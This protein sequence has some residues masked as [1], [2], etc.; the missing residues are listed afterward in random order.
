MLKNTIYLLLLIVSP[1]SGFAQDWVPVI[2][3]FGYNA[4]D[5]ELAFSCYVKNIDDDNDAEPTAYKIII[6]NISDN[7]EIFSADVPLDEIKQLSS[8]SSKSWTI[9]LPALA[10]Y[11]PDISYKIAVLAN[12]NG[13]F[14]FDKKNNRVESA[15]FACGQA[16]LSNAQAQPAGG[17]SGTSEKSTAKPA[18]AASDM[19]DLAKDVADMKASRDQMM[20]DSKAAKEQEKQTLTSKVENL[21]Q[22]V[23]KRIA[24]RDEY[25]K[26]TKDWSD[27]AYEVADL[28]LELKISETELEKVT[29]ELAYGQEGLSKSEKERYKTKLDKLE[30][31]QSENKKNK[32]NGLLFGQTTAAPANDVKEPV[33]STE[34]EPAAEETEV[35]KYYSAEEIAQLSV[36]DIKKLKF[37]SN[38]LIG[39][40]KVKLKTKGSYLSPAEKTAL[41]TEIAELTKQVELAEAELAKRE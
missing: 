24:E 30:S 23:P 31:Q 20:A 17:G 26:G 35:T 12:T 16:A 9:D 25:E 39:R 27:M 19:R 15:Q 33:K 4:S 1:I 6:F 13:K 21:K 8:S 41:E 22:K 34:K 28:E 38:T 32:K 29:D 40:R 18:D 11:R 37:D 14:E 10:G 5:C 2:S 3:K 7:S 36:H